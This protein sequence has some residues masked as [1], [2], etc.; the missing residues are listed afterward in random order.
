M[1]RQHKVGSL[2]DAV[3]MIRDGATIAIGG[4]KNQRVP[5]ALVREIAR[6]GKTDLHIVDGGEHVLRARL[7]AAAAGLAFM[8]LDPSTERSTDRAIEAVDDPFTGKTILVAAAL[9]PDV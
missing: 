6:Q 3:A 5:M 7:K 8:P 2:T 1:E 9:H 4:R